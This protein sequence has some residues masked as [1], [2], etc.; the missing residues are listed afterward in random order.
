MSEWQINDF[1]DPQKVGAEN[2]SK[3]EYMF[4]VFKARLID[5]LKLNGHAVQGVLCGGVK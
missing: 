4:Q 2:A 3:H 5:E 1:F